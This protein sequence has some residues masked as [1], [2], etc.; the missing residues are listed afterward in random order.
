[1]IAGLT[2]VSAPLLSAAEDLRL[3]LVPTS[4]SFPLGD[5]IRITW[6]LEN[7][8][9]NVLSVVAYR[10]AGSTPQFDEL[11]LSVSR[12]NGPWQTVSFSAPRAATRI[13]WRDLDPGATLFQQF[14]LAAAMGAS[15]IKVEPGAYRLK[16]EYTLGAMRTDSGRPSWSG[17]VAT[18]QNADFILG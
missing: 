16:G 17:H 6:L 8:S 15:G 12:N 13:V 2:G 7:R 9:K 4:K 18:D 11:S 3:I 1:M 14:D 10:E 5:P